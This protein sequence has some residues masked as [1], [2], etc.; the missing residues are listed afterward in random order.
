MIHGLYRALVAT[1]AVIHRHDG[2]LVAL[3]AL[4]GIGFRPGLVNVFGQDQ[5]TLH[6]ASG[7]AGEAEEG[8]EEWSVF[9]TSLIARPGEQVKDESSHKANVI[10]SDQRK[11]GNPSIR[12]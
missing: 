2:R 4:R 8:K 7:E 5:I 12:A 3:R 1:G 6:A 9:H 11:R 10:A